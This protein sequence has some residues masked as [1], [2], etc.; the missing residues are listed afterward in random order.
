MLEN[1]HVKLLEA[2]YNDRKFYEKNTIN[3]IK[4]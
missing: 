2:S 1:L 4:T 3:S